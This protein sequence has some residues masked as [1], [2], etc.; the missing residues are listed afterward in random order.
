MFS[1]SGVEKLNLKAWSTEAVEYAQNMFS[2]AANLKE[3]DISN[4]NTRNIVDMDGFLDDVDK[5]NKLALG[6]MFC[7]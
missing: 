2:G 5:L 7:V 6:N 1:D 4:F 3:L